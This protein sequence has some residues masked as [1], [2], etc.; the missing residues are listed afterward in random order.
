MRRSSSL[1]T[2]LL[3][4]ASCASTDG[5]KA[6]KADGAR[7]QPDSGPRMVPSSELPPDYVAAARSWKEGGEAWRAWRDGALADPALA[8][9]LVDNLV[10]VMID[11][12]A[13]SRLAT[14]GQV[15]GPFE[16]AQEDLVFLKERS[17]PVLVE[18]LAVG[19]NVAAFLAGD[20]LVQMD[21]PSVAPLV[22]AKLAAPE[23][24]TRRRAA[25][26]LGRLPHAHE[27]EEAVL[28]A[29][30]R[31]LREDPE[32]SVR[33]EA[34]RA[35]ALRGGR[36]RDTTRSVR[37]LSLALSDPDPAVME[38]AAK[39]LATLRDPR[40]LPALVNA[41]ERTLHES[42]RPKSVLVVQKSLEQLTGT[43]EPQTPDAWRKWLRD[44]A[45]ARR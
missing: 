3:A 33:A 25:E 31:A 30:E 38:A 43:K 39:G 44:A 1:V 26:V 7:S 42:D 5:S 21:D 6:P 12:Y 11:S 45:A 40:A 29:L 14:T 20:V 34:A 19:D 24:E 36:D 35:V 32:W 28:D 41:L 23:R 9:F 2:W 18:L 10:G 4:L 13:S 15:A 17:T 8:D 37:A 16:R 22:A 27:D